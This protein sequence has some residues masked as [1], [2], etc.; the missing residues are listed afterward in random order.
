MA[1][2]QPN[3]DLEDA[4]TDC[5]PEI[6]PEIKRD[7][8]SSLEAEPYDDVV[9][10]S[11]D[12]T[13]YVPLLDDEVKLGSQEPKS[14][15]HADGTPVEC[16]AEGQRAV[17]ENGDHE[18][19]EN[20]TTGSFEVI[21][22]EKPYSEFM[23]HQDHWPQEEQFGFEPQ[24]VFQLINQP[25]PFDLNREDDVLSDMLLPPD[26]RKTRPAFTKNF[27]TSEELTAAMVPE[28]CLI[29]TTYAPAELDTSALISQNPGSEAQLISAATTEEAA[30]EA[31]WLEA[32]RRHVEGAETL[33]EEAS[34][35]VT[36]TPGE[37][38]SEE[39]LKEASFFSMEPMRDGHTAM[40]WQPTEQEQLALD[41][42]HIPEPPRRAEEAEFTL[43]EASAAVTAETKF[44][45]ET[46][47]AGVQHTESIV[48]TETP[49]LIECNEPLSEHIAS[50]AAVVPAGQKTTERQSDVQPAQTFSEDLIERRMEVAETP[51]P[52]EPSAPPLDLLI[53]IPLAMK[54]HMEPQEP[55]ETVETRVSLP[56]AAASATEG[57]IP[58]KEEKEADIVRHE[59]AQESAASLR[60]A[61]K[62][63]DCRFGNAKPV[64][65]APEEL[66]VGPPQLKSLDP[67]LEVESGSV[68]AWLKNQALHKK[69]A[70]L[71]EMRREVRDTWD[72]D[73]PQ[74]V[75]KKKKR[76]PKQKRSGQPRAVEPFEN[77]ASS[78]DLATPQ[79][80]IEVQKSGVS[81]GSG[82]AYPLKSK[83]LIT[84]T[85]DSKTVVKEVKREVMKMIS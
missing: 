83:D 71:A 33:I 5:P 43:P 38:P 9:G 27:G 54:Q 4:L 13:D 29:D 45:E 48:S 75:M 44:T 24:P 41:R 17:L 68:A 14:K 40:V 8:I 52:L 37:T 22:D 20:D 77:V 62:P 19:G 53:E 64:S 46:K 55:E 30:F 7:F 72:P 69:A 1:D 15:Y 84:P 79:S 18:I 63:S 2:L 78:T 82:T 76:K 70:E 10:E 60:Q 11:C 31:D 59:S 23:P 58:K 34:E 42:H 26:D 28:E 49:F 36:V 32:Q 74:T 85:E 67:T 47:A 50:D 80:A 65:H 73:S 81:F 21:V 66:P 16:M 39:S 57:T 51:A 12:K 25:N 6:E 3:L 35:T 61:Y 56:E